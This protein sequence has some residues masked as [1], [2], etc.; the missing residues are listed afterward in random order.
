MDHSH[1]LSEAPDQTFSSK[2]SPPTRVKSIDLTQLIISG[3]R[4][5]G[6]RAASS[7]TSRSAAESTC[8]TGTAAIALRVYRLE[9]ILNFSVPQ[10]EREQAQLEETVASL[11]EEVSALTARVD[12]WKGILDDGRVEHSDHSDRSG[13]LCSPPHSA[14]IRA[15]NGAFPV[16]DDVHDVASSME[17]SKIPVLS[18][19][20]MAS[21]S[22]VQPH[23]MDEGRHNKSPRFHHSSPSGR[24]E[25]HGTSEHVEPSCNGR[26]LHVH[27][28]GGVRSGELC[29]EYLTA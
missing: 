14:G 28:Q 6:Y 20:V 21:D 26:G 15:S 17:L 27:S 3:V 7:P 29:V 25:E 19:S 11:R 18:A 16:S 24:Y 10:E 4:P 13:A 9:E 8:G 23:D 1:S 22:G 12:K 5:E 2:Q